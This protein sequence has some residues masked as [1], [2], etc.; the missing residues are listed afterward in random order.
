MRTVGMGSL[1]DD[2]TP[3]SAWKKENKELKKAIKELTTEN[4]ALKKSVEELTAE[5]V[6]LITELD[7]LSGAEAERGDSAK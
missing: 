7:A 1:K 3:E 2:K 5:N 4:A 6:A